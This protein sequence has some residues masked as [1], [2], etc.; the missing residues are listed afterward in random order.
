MQWLYSSIVLKSPSQAQEIPI[1]FPTACALR[2]QRWLLVLQEE[3]YT[4]K[5]ESLS[6][7]C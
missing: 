2:G 5:N 7:W 1:V 4:L 6:P 3:I